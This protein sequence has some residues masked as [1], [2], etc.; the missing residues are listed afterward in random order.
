MLL[1]SLQMCHFLSEKR[2]TKAVCV[3]RNV[4]PDCKMCV[5]DTNMG[6]TIDNLAHFSSK[7]CKS[8]LLVYD[9]RINTDSV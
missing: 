6:K 2:V 3:P 7:I 8:H 9:K 1:F 5:R 4:S